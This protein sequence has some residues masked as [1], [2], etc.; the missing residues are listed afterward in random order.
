MTIRVYAIVFFDPQ[1]MQTLTHK[2]YENELRWFER[3]LIKEFVS[4]SS[5]ELI[6][7]I[8]LHFENSPSLNKEFAIPFGNN[9]FTVFITLSEVC[10]M[11]MGCAL[12]VSGSIESRMPHLASMKLIN[13]YAQ[14]GDEGIPKEATKIV[15][16]FKTDILKDDLERTKQVLKRSISSVLK[17]G[18][19]IEDLIEKTET[20]SMSS[21]IFFERSR[22][23]NRCC[24]IIPRFWH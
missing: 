10:K 8:D 13:N 18:E 7:K 20:L 12:M 24:W 1:S 22:N 17:R 6:S 4:F 23:L 15:A 9:D 14:Y 11:M 5:D 19:K 3:T 2:I 21:K 16:F